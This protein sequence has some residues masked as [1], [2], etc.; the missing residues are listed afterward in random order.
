MAIKPEQFMSLEV[1]KERMDY[2][3][4]RVV[5]SD[6]MPGVDRIYFPGGI[7]QLKQDTAIAL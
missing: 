6:K 3:H 7:E 5:E 4:S 1:F 2:L